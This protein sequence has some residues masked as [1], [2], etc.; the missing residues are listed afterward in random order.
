MW[1]NGYYGDLAPPK[2]GQAADRRRRMHARSDYCISRR[3]GRRR[4][5]IF[6]VDV[7]QLALNLALSFLA[8]CLGTD[9]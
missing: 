9:T 1:M 4:C 7:E 8:L 3:R 2:I 5:G 6:A